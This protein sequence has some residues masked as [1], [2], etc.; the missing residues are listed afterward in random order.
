MHTPIPL[1]Q[2][3]KLAADRASQPDKIKRDAFL[4][5]DNAADSPQ[6][7]QCGPCFHFDKDNEI[8]AVFLWEEADVTAVDS[9]GLFVPGTYDGHRVKEGEGVSRKEADFAIDTQV[10]CENCNYGGDDCELYAMLNEALPN[11]FDLE[12]KI[13]SQG[14]CNAFTKMSDKMKAYDAYSFGY[15]LGLCFDVGELFGSGGGGST[16]DHK[17][18]RQQDV[19]RAAR[20]QGL[21][22]DKIPN[23]PD[24]SPIVTSPVK[25]SYPEKRGIDIGNTVSYRYTNVNR[26]AGQGYGRV[27][28]FVHNKGYGRN[29]QYLPGDSPEDVAIL[30]VK[31]K[32]LQ[33][34]SSRNVLKTKTAHDEA[35]D[36][37][38]FKEELHKRDEGGKFTKGS[39]GGGAKKEDKGEKPDLKDLYSDNL[40]IPRHLMPQ[41][42][43]KF[44]PQ[45]LNQLRKDGV[46]VKIENVDAKTLKPSQKDFNPNEIDTVRK[47]VA[48]GEFKVEPNPIIVSKDNRVIDG[49]HRWAVAAQ[50]GKEI[51]AIRVNLNAKELIAKASEFAKEN[52]IGARSRVQEP[53]AITEYKKKWQGRPLSSLSDEDITNKIADAAKTFSSIPATDKIDTPERKALRKKIAKD[54]YEKDI[55]NRQQGRDA[56]II[57]GLPA[58]GKSTLANP[59]IKEKGALEVDPDLAKEQLPEY[60]N[61]LG[62]SAVHEESSSIT[63]DVM[64]KALA[65]GDNIV[66]PRVDSPE[67]VVK[68]IQN[69]KRLGYKVNVRML[70]VDPTLAKQSSLKR[71][72]ENG[73]FLNP[74]LIDEVGT[75]AMESYEAAKSSGVLE[76][77]ELWRREGNNKPTKVEE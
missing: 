57:L 59:I 1:S 67:K 27:L 49:H 55:A 14:C 77:A 28:G 16:V 54:L 73:R 7:A 72:L 36:E 24:G 22:I 39:G 23:R 52:D 20:K 17:A 61:G 32:T 26:E 41:I 30:D 50:D 76:S 11:V 38:E 64:A 51:D 29:K 4:Y 15:G 21:D 70:D 58:S 13:N 65:N 75:K 3:L 37:G 18:A 46:D 10:R 8:C 35:F 68:D 19:L 33:F 48:A 45:F 56:T 44:K 42:P 60:Y 12:T 31:N 69:L 40:G 66:W 53:A 25:G 47:A 9:C 62:S 74:S 34:V 5:F 63:R 2:W 71:F 6:F 43:N